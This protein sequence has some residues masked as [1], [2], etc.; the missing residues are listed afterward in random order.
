L[1]T[2][3]TNTPAWF[4]KLV[5]TCLAKEPGLRPADGATLVHAVEYGEAAQG[6]GLAATVRRMFRR[7]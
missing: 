4:C 3:S 6:G 5:T 7:A 1:S 2:H